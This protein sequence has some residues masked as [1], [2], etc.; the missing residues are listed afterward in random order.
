MVCVATGKPPFRNIAPPMILF[1]T[2]NFL[3]GIGGIQNYV[4]GLADAF[5]ARGEK[6]AV[7][8]DRE[9][10]PGTALAIDN[11]RVYP[12]HRFGG[13]R[14]WRSW[15][16]ARAVRKRLTVGDVRAVIADS[17][18]GLVQM[19]RSGLGQARVM[20]LAHGAEL[21]VPPRSAK[22]RRISRA[23][24]KADIVAANSHFTAGLVR[25]FVSGKTEVRI[26][27][28]GVST[29]PGAPLTF[30]TRARVEAKRLLTIARLDPYKG[31]DRVL[32]AL[33]ALVQRH[34]AVHYDVVGSGADA[35]RLHALAR[36]LRVERHV[37]FHGR[38]DESMK[39]ELLR[40][41]DIFVLPSRLEPGEVE[42]FGIVYVEAGAFGVPSI[43]GR[44]GGTPDAVLD[45]KTGLLVD[46]N[47]SGAI[48]ASVSRLL[49][50]PALAA[51]MGRAAF[52]RFWSEFAWESAIGRFAD[53]LCL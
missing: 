25:P 17:W 30:P 22:G 7:F 2:Q 47:A 21:L 16:K 12:I 1:T 18:K 41:A 6:I 9:D 14:P 37:T 38:V 45:G 15:R 52:E 35:A 10:E 33:P 29:P 8:C 19:P 44:D 36:S 39:A 11:T 5:A 42:G 46:G 4:T 50:D 23:F 48:A 32:Q 49:D 34:G 20:C 13:P 31:I 28:P 40:K 43:A 26:L 51:E 24:A 27:L 3:P 53:V